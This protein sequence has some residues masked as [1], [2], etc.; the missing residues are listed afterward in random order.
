MNHSNRIFTL[1]KWLELRGL[2]YHY[3]MVVTPFAKLLLVS[4]F[5]LCAA[6]GCKKKSA[7][8]PAGAGAQP[9]AGS[10]RVTQGASDAATPT[11][12]APASPQAS[13][14]PANTAMAPAPTMDRV[15]G[16]YFRYALKLRTAV[17]AAAG[18]CGKLAEGLRALHAEAAGLRSQSAPFVAN[19]ATADEF[20]AMVVA[21]MGELMAPVNAAVRKCSDADTTRALQG[22][23]LR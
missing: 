11:P 1:S 15:S 14:P 16:Q 8:P 18:D 23:V 10:A 9:A 7:A 5:M 22:A 4:G 3:R 12:L 21:K 2:R 19:A 6:M 17:T 13:A 20:A